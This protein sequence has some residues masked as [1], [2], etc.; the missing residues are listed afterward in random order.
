MMNLL[1]Y[2]CTAAGNTG[3]D[4]EDVGNWLCETNIMMQQQVKYEVCYDM[5]CI[6]NDRKILA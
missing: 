2:E 4:A 3:N 1:I 5:E 6:A